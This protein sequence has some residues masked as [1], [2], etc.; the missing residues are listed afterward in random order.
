VGGE[1][2]LLDAQYRTDEPMPALPEALDRSDSASSAIASSEVNSSHY[3]GAPPATAWDG[4][5]TTDDSAFDFGPLPVLKSTG[6]SMEIAEIP[7]YVPKE[8][9]KA[10][11]LNLRLRHQR[12]CQLL[13]HFL[14]NMYF[15]KKK[16]LGAVFVNGYPNVYCY[17]E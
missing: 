13:I 7:P 17:I 5:K 6:P 8:E 12:V 2:S 15:C 11:S 1:E 10:V 16:T 3:S 14:I 9:D 4:V